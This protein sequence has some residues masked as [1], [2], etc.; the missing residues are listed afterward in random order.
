MVVGIPIA[1]FA[2]NHSR[3]AAVVIGLVV[4]IGMVCFT[5]FSQLY[6]MLLLARMVAGIGEVGVEMTIIKSV[7]TN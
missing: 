6:W 1:R 2:D 4:W 3:V 5:A 7:F